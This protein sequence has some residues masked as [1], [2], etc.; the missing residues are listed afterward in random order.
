M[1]EEVFGGPTEGALAAA[2]AFEVPIA[3]VP[4][5][6]VGLGLEADRVAVAT[7]ACCLDWLSPCSSFTAVLSGTLLRLSVFASNNLNV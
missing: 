1:L 3:G 5:Y 6:C 7:S 4:T 2:A